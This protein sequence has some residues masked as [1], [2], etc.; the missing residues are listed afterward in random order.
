MAKLIYKFNGLEQPG[1][2]IAVSVSPIGSQDDYLKRKS[3]WVNSFPGWKLTGGWAASE[4][5]K[6]SVVEFEM[7]GSGFKEKPPIPANKLEWPLTGRENPGDKIWVEVGYLRD[8]PDFNNKKHHWINALGGW[9]LT[10]AWKVVRPGLCKA[11]F[12]MEVPKIFNMNGQMQNIADVFITNIT[13]YEP[14]GSYTFVE[15]GGISDY[16]DL[17][18]RRF[19][20]ESRLPCWKLTGSLFE[21]ENKMMVE[22]KKDRGG[23]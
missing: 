4:S 7:I 16:N 11:E 14:I 13:G 15:V 12:Q 1:M 8:Q 9:N 18:M 2:R 22:F 10:G 6:M 5:G 23:V 21:T 3:Q 17:K 20:L 19:E